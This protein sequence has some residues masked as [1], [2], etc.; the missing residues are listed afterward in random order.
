M[1]EKIH[2]VLGNPS[3]VWGKLTKPRNRSMLWARPKTEGTQKA[4]R[5]SQALVKDWV[6]V[7]QRHMWFDLIAS[8]APPE[9]TERQPNAVLLSLLLLLP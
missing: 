3:L 6:K 5:L 8:W 7:T 1:R 2:M 4:K 9:K